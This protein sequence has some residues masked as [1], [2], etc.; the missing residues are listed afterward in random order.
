MKKLDV[1]DTKVKKGVSS[2]YPRNIE[3]AFETM[4][5]NSDLISKK[6]AS[7]DKLHIEHTN[8]IKELTERV[9]SLVAGYEAKAKSGAKVKSKA[10]K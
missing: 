1:V 6:I 4:N 7:F 5:K 3:T 10:K 9:D 2:V 8:K